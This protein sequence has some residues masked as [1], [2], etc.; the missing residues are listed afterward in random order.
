VATRFRITASTTAPAV[1]PALQSYSHNAPSTVRRE[2]LTS[3][4][5]ALSTFAYAPDGA[6]DLVAGDALLG[7]FVSAP[8]VSGINFTS[9]DVIKFAVQC[10]E[11]NAG[12]NV[13]LQCWV[14]VYSQDG[15]TLR[16]E[17]RAKVSEGTE[18]A[19][20]LT[21]RFLSTT[22]GG[23]TY[24]TVAGDRLV[25]EFS[26]VGTPT[27][28]GG[29]Q[30]HNASIR[31]GGAGAGG[32]APENDTE[33]GTTVNGWIEVIPTITFLTTSVAGRLALLGVGV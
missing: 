5:S 20:T 11:A 9:A 25:V 18:M 12:N 7:Q 21:N 8:M 24:T 30:G 6:D 14:G 3:D 33:T 10:L 19:T 2:L 15:T 27:G 31:L 13:A 23:A 4:S 28:A 32:D 22:Q 1:S 29:V 26:C 17:L 16:R